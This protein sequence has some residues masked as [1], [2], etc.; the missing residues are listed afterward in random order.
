MGLSMPKSM[1]ASG[2]LSV[3]K[4]LGTRRTRNHRA[5]LDAGGRCLT[6]P[7]A[8]AGHQKPRQRPRQRP[9]PMSNHTCRLIAIAIVAAV[10]LALHDPP[11]YPPPTAESLG[12]NA[13]R[14]HWGV[15]G[16]H[17]TGWQV[18]QLPGRW[19]ADS[20][21]PRGVTVVERSGVVTVRGARTGRVMLFAG[22]ETVEQEI[23]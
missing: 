12:H 22:S 5:H 8:R 4:W 6:H 2:G 17:L 19:Q 18:R 10:L 11:T 7:N 13:Y 16:A 1:V 9:Q 15:P 23:D 20:L 3:T 14:V 21:H